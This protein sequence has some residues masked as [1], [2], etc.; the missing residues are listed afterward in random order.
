[1]VRTLGPLLAT[2]VVTMVI[3]LVVTPADE[4][5]VVGIVGLVLLF[6]VGLSAWLVTRTRL[7]IS[8]E[9]ITYHAIGYLVRGRWDDVARVEKR[10]IG[11]SD[12]ESLILRE[13]GIRM[14][15]W[16]DLS[17]RFLPV[18]AVLGALQ[19]R[20]VPA[21]PLA[22]LADAIPVGTFDPDWRTGEIGALVRRYAPQ[23]FETQPG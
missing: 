11:A 17:Y 4:W 22:Q 20:H 19:G 7:E 16:M 23:A 2:C 5:S 14:S 3:L 13:P 10:V 12:V 18:A 21:T 6:G 8:P 1:M 9:G 15:G